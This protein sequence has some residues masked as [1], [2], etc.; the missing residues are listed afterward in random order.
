MPISWT[1]NCFLGCQYISHTSPQVT[2]KSWILTSEK[3]G[4]NCPNWGQG[5]RGGGLGN[6][7]NA[8]KKTFFFQLISSLTTKEMVKK[9]S[10]NIFQTFRCSENALSI[11]CTAML[12]IKS[13]WRICAPKFFLLTI[14]WLPALWS[15]LAPALRKLCMDSRSWQAARVHKWSSTLSCQGFHKIILHRYSTTTLV[16]SKSW[17]WTLEQRD[18]EIHANPDHVW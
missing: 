15:W 6:S 13:R 17:D 18:K 9:F 1:F 3:K 16:N 4:P 11:R 7:G 5:G 12:E 8:R 14:H 2:F 10:R